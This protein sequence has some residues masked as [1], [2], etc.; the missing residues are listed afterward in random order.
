MKNL[1]VKSHERLTNEHEHV[2]TVKKSMHSGIKLLGCI[3]S[4]ELKESK[5]IIN[6]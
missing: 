4:L 6:C 2:R 3:K 5:I 1:Y